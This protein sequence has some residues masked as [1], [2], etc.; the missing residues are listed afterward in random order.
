MEEVSQVIRQRP[1]SETEEEK[2]RENLEQEVER[3]SKESGVEPQLIREALEKEAAVRQ[4]VVERESSRDAPFY[5]VEKRGGQ[6]VLKINTAHRFFTD[7][8]A[9]I[10]GPEGFRLRSALELLLF[11]LGQ[12]ETDADQNGQIWY[13]SERI[14]W[15]RRLNAALTLLEDYI[16]VNVPDPDLEFGELS[17]D[18]DSE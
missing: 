5:R 4:F 8:Y 6:Y 11:V 2:A 12:C 16:D 7:V 13:V 17:T 1:T 3:R 10:E 9:A 15:S 14:E 18:I